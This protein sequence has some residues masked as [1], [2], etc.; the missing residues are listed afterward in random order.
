[1][2]TTSGI[3]LSLRLLRDGQ[4]VHRP[5]GVLRISAERACR[6][7]E[8]A[9]YSIAQNVAHAELWQRVWLA[10]LELTEPPKGS[11]IDWDWPS[12]SESAWAEWRARFL[13]GLD[14]AI[15]Y[16]E[17]T[18]L[19]PEQEFVLNQILIHDT[20]H[21]GQCVLLKRMLAR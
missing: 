19:T 3:A 2:A 18:D 9:P 12:V 4:D 7:L 1:M 10:K 11:F 16:A 6:R 8:N 15:A 14:R 17:G 5:S 21:L 20:Y 13:D